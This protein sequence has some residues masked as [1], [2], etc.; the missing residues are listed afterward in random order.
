LVLRLAQTHGYK[1]SGREDGKQQ[2]DDEYRNT[3]EDIREILVL[4]GITSLALGKVYFTV[5]GSNLDAKHVLA[6]LY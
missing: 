6:I 3:V 2:D 1:C 5:Y 4:L